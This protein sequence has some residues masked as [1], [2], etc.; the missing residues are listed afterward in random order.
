MAYGRVLVDDVQIKSNNAMQTRSTHFP[1]YRHSR[2]L[3]VFE[4]HPLFF[5]GTHLFFFSLSDP[6]LLFVLRCHNLVAKQRIICRNWR[7]DV[8]TRRCRQMP[9]KK[10]LTGKRRNFC[11]V[12]MSDDDANLPSKST[13]SQPAMP[14]LDFSRCTKCDV[15]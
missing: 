1:I 12:C 13:V 10:T 2:F 4:F 11:I 15:E 6:L 8:G 5:N 7:E 14:S 3:L 9:K